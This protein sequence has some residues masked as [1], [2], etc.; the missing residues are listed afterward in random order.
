MET[1]VQFA[2]LDPTFWGAYLELWSDCE[3]K[4]SFQAPLFLQ[5]LA[6]IAAGSLNV[7]SATINGKLIGATF[8]YKRGG[9]YHF[10]SDMKT[11][12]NYFILRKGITPQETKQYFQAFVREIEK[13]K[14]TFRLN[15]QPSWASYMD[16]FKTA[17]SESNLYWKISKYNPCL[18][19]EAETPEALHAATNKQKLR[20]KLYRLRDMD[21]V[22]FEAFQGDE[23]LDLWLAEFYA[24]HIRRWEDT[25][26]PSHFRKPETRVF[27]ESC[28]RTWIDT[29]IAVRFSIKL[30]KKRIAFVTALLENGYLVHHTTTFDPDYE[31]QSP[32]LIIINLIG[33]WMQER[34]MAKMEFG[35]GGEAY[36]YQFAKQEFPLNT[37]F[38]TDKRNYPYILKT[39]LINSIKEN[40]GIHTFYGT[41]IRP[42][43]LRSKVLKKLIT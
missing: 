27:Y 26:T 17:L 30:G 1:L 42:V 18:V 40:K 13:N 29:G 32:G 3:Y 35:D 43:M 31:K 11:D 24:A 34:N 12:H 4:S 41:K 28:L 10:L 7:F 6:T 38:I 21:E 36:K 5:F 22:A 33:K 16:T 9:E 39:K 19:L 8:F 23:D 25:P 2:L 15:N 37:I 14:W 20:Q